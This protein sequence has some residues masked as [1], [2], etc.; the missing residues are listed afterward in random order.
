MRSTFEKVRPER[1]LSSA[2]SATAGQAAAR[3]EVE[4]DVQAVLSVCGHQEPL[5]CLS[6]AA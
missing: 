3:M 2:T 1:A 6:E 5:D 4:G